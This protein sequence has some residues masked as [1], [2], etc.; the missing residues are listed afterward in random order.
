MKLN[1]SKLE[2]EYDPMRQGNEI[3]KLLKAL[4][5]VSFQADIQ[6]PDNDGF[7][8]VGG[9]DPSTLISAIASIVDFERDAKDKK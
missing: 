4:D 9:K 5:I 3:L 2:I 7:F 6:S 8:C 1:F